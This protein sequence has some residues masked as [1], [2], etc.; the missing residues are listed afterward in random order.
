MLPRVFTETVMKTAARGGGTTF[1]T[2]DE[3][4][5]RIELFLKDPKKRGARKVQETEEMRKAKRSKIFDTSSDDS[6]C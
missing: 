5:K 1:I 6:T 4:K 2:E 3:I